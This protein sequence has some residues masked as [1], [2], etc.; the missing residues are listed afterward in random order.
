M[1]QKLSALNTFLREHNLSIKDL[2]KM[3]EIV[4]FYNGIPLVDDGVKL[5][6]SLRYTDNVLSQT[7]TMMKPIKSVHFCGVDIALKDAPVILPYDAAVKFC[8][9][10][11]GKLL[12]SSQ[13]FLI[14]SELD[15]INNTLSL[16]GADAFA[17]KDYWLAD[18]ASKPYTAKVFN[19]KTRKIREVNKRESHL[20]RVIF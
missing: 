14:C 3:M 5:F 10:Q 2:Q 8:S 18:K 20:C 6:V 11:G 19:F 1:K 13:V 15:R 17:D 4:N 9:Q 12:T 16:I 7:F